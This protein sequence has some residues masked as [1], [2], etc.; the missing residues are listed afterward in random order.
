MRSIRHGWAGGAGKYYNIATM[1]T[2]PRHTYGILACSEIV[3]NQ[4]DPFQFGLM[5]CGCVYRDY[6]ARCGADCSTA[7]QIV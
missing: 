6:A 1:V 4:A 5:D 3:F 2:F 7:A